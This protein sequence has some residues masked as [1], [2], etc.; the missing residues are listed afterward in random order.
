MIRLS[1]IKLPIGYTDADI[2]KACAKELRIPT[3][4]IDRTALYR[5]SI[6]ARRKEDIRYVTSVDIHL[7]INETAAL[8]RA[9]SKNAALC[10]EYRYIPTEGSGKASSDR[11]RGS[12]GTVLRA[13]LSTKRNPS[14][15]D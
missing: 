6:D 15:P 14:H 5:R 9:K 12:C 2:L 7:N 3:D 4:A 13:D 8:S 1:N 11:R 10:E